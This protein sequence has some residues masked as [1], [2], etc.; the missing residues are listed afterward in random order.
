MNTLLLIMHVIASL[1]VVAFAVYTLVE[2]FRLQSLHSRVGRITQKMRP[3]IAGRGTRKH[4]IDVLV[5]DGFPKD[6]V[7]EL[8]DRLSR[9]ILPAKE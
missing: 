7:E 1:F 4:I 3:L 5:L 2:V 6:E 8:Y 9:E